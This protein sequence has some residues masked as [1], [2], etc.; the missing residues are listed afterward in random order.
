M[1]GKRKCFYISERHAKWLQE[2]AEINMKSES[3][4]VKLAIEELIEQTGGYDG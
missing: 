1:K 2:M 3:W 4:L